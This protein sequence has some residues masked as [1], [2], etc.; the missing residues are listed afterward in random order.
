MAHVQAH[1][2]GAG[3]QQALL[4]RPRH[5]IAGREL[6]DEALARRVQ[7]PG[8]LA[9][10]RFGD[11]EAVGAVVP[12]D[13]SGMKLHQLQVGQVSSGVV[14]EEQAAAG[15]ADRVRGARPQRGGA[16]GGQHRGGRVDPRPVGQS[17]PD[18]N[19]IGRDDLHHPPLLEHR[20]PLILGDERRELADDPPAGG[21]SAGVHHAPGR[22]A[23]LQAEREVPVTVGIEADTERGQVL[24]R[25]RRLRAQHACG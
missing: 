10:H 15:G 5:L 16:A 8:A 24:D 6:V 9:A 25:R 7:Q 22:V 1:R 4:H 14:P 23:S 13:C 2:G 11:Q 19:P 3:G 21:R 17:H 20:D 18:G 12:D